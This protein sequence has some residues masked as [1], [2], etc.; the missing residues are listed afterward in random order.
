LTETRVYI[1]GRSADQ[2]SSRAVNYHSHV[3]CAGLK[4]AG[5]IRPRDLNT[6]KAAQRCTLCWPELR[7]WDLVAHDTERD[8]DSEYEARFVREVLSRVRGLEPH[9]V[10]PQREVRLSDGRSLR[11]DFFVDR[12]D[13]RPLAIELD[14]YNKTGRVEDAPAVARA[15]KAK[16]RQLEQ[17]LGYEVVEFAVQDL[18]DP[19]V[20]IRDIETRIASKPIVAA[21]A[22]EP[23]ERARREQNGALGD[24][25]PGQRSKRVPVLV[26]LTTLGV[27]VVAAFAFRAMND[28]ASSRTPASDGSCPGEANI[29]GNVS[30]SG[31]RIFHEPGWRYYDATNAEECFTSAKDAEE[32][33][34]RASQAQ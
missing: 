16:R 5:S 34:Y 1:T 12:R 10:T 24:T 29:K 23:D 15:D 20:A 33:G 19:H 21:S 18:S 11:I 25:P 8:G 32:A 2:A 7:G 30:M 27:V 3:H 6:L 22:P 9:D 31:E 14:G 17:Q 13:L 4:G 26:A 28:D